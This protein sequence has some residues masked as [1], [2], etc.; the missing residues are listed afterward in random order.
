[1]NFVHERS[2]NTKLEESSLYG[3]IDRL[4]TETACLEL[5]VW[6]YVPGNA[7]LELRACNCVPGTTCP[8]LHSWNC[9]HGTACLDLRAC[10]CVWR[11]SGR[12]EETLRET[13]TLI[14]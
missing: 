8:E 3:F 14:D 7:C 12:R 4:V 9:V 6:N 13:S 5:R 11:V 2:N 10:N 1:M